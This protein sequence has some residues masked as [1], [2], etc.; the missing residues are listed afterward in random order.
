M[1][2]TLRE[3]KRYLA[4]AVIGSAPKHAVIKAMNTALLSYLGEY[5]LGE[6]G[7]FPLPETWT[8][9]G[10]ILR[11]EH[12]HVNEVKAALALAT[13]EDIIFHTKGVSGLLHK[14]KALIGG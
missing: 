6:A 11:A 5:G 8:D 1:K 3:K 13:Q 9:K 7:A 12:D 14:A 4:V 2:P 10:I